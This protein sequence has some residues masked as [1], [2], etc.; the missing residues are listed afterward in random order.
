MYVVSMC[1]KLLYL[2]FHPRIGHR[3]SD[4]CGTTITY[5]HLDCS[6]SQL[7]FFRFADHMLKAHGEKEFHVADDHAH[8]HP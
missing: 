7:I 3:R 5:H 6:V 2:E 1:A 8:V 4:V